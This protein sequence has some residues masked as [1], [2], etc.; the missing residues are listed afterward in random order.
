VSGFLS[1]YLCMAQMWTAWTKFV[2]HRYIV[3]QIVGNSTGV[4][5]W[6]TVDLWT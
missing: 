6:A 5:T 2:E 3:H 1:S 4:R